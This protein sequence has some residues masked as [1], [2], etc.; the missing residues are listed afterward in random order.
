MYDES[1]S[2]SL[3]RSILKELKIH[4]ALY[5]STFHKISYLKNS[6]ISPTELLDKDESFGFEE[7]FA[8]IYVRY[9]DELKRNNVIDCDDL[10]LLTI[11]LFE[12][13]KKI[14]DLY[15]NKI[16]YILYDDFHDATIAEYKFLHLLSENH[17]NL[18]VT[19]DANQ[20]FNRSDDNS[21]NLSVLSF[22][23]DFPDAEIIVFETNQRSTKNILEAASTIISKNVSK[24]EQEKSLPQSTAKDQ[25]PDVC[26]CI[27]NTDEEESFYIART[28]KEFFLKGKY[29]YKDFGIFFR[30]GQ[31]CRSIEDALKIEGLPYKVVDGLSLF[32]KKEVK[33]ILAYLKVILKWN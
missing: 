33:D 15:K 31:Q 7:K 19:V 27:T 28:I 3:L 12:K 17:K 1:D 2:C 13:N 20:G 6:L 32:H 24:T 25:G 11:N 8:R 9:L 4:E 14:L 10:L 26:C 21:S 22:K 23:K 18:C 5:Q 29:R 30:I 16:S